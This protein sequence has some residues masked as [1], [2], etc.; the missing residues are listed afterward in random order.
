MHV[1]TVIRR[2]VNKNILRVKSLATT[3]LT[4]NPPKGGRN[5]EKITSHWQ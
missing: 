1:Q 3:G 4:L 2:N 5:K